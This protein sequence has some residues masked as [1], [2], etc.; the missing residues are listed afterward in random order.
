MACNCSKCNPS[1]SCGCSDTA[2]HTPCFYTECTVGNERCSEI[3]CAECVSYCGTGFRIVSGNNIFQVNPGDRYDMILQ[4]LSL[5]IVNGFGACNADNLHHAPYNLYAKNI[6]NTA[7]AILWNN[8]SSLSTG[9]SIY[10][11]TLTGTG[12]WILANSI[13][14]APAVLKYELKNLTP[15]TNYKIKLVSLY[16]NSPCDSVEILIKTLV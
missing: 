6:T 13:P 10:Y 4:K 11:N 5:M 2:L 9:I 15:N 1:G 12:P 16:Q 7:A 14:V 3:S 8:E